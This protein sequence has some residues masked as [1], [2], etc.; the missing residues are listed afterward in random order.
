MRCEGE[1]AMKLNFYRTR[2]CKREA[3]EGSCFCRLHDPALEKERAAAK[4]ARWEAR[5][6]LAH[7]MRFEAVLKKP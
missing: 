2:Q 5:Q 4:Q 3:Q 6:P 1:V 7:A